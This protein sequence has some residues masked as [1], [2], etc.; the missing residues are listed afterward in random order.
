MIEYEVCSE[1]YLRS[2]KQVNPNRLSLDE[3]VFHIIGRPDQIWF[4]DSYCEI[5][6]YKTQA[7][8]NLI[9]KKGGTYVKSEDSKNI[10]CVIFGAQPSVRAIKYF[11]GKAKF[12]SAENAVRWLEKQVNYT[13]ACR[14]FGPKYHFSED[15]RLRP[16]QQLIKKRVFKIWES[17]YNIMIQLPTGTGKTVL[18]TSIINDLTKVKG[19]KI[20]ILAHRKELI[21][22]ISEHLSHYNIEH[23]L[24]TS[25][26]ARR[27]ELSVQ[28]AS[29]QTLT[30]EK[31]ID[32]LKEL[33]PQ[34]IIIDEAH[35]SLAE[36]YTKFWKECGNC[37]KLGV[38][39]TPY[40]LNLN[41]FLS[42][43]EKYVES[44][45]IEG[46]IRNGYLADYDFYTDNPNSYLSRTIESIK[47]KS[48]TRDYNTATLLRALNIQEHIQRLI[49]CYE[50]Y[51]KGKKGIVYAINKEHAHN[52]C[53]AYQIIGVKA[54]Y[55]DSD[56]PKSE[57][58]EIVE[59]FRDSE[60]Q[61]MVNV[62][63]FSEG[64]DCP[65]VEF[66]QLARP[67]W[68]LGKY[69]QQ[70]GRG[71][72]PS[73]NKQ[74]T[75]I[76]D[77]A[78]MFVKFGFPS[79]KR[80]WLTYFNGEFWL[81]DYQG[82]EEYDYV[83]YLCQA[84]T[85]RNEMMV[86]LNRGIGRTDKIVEVQAKQDKEDADLYR[87]IQVINYNAKLDKIKKEKEEARRKE[88]A[89]KKEARKKEQR[90]YV[91]EHT[92]RAILESPYFEKKA[93]VYGTFKNIGERDAEYVINALGAKVTQTI[94]PTTNFVFLADKSDFSWKDEVEVYDFHP[95][96]Y[97]EEEI[98][99][100]LELYKSI[101]P[102]IIDEDISK[103][104]PFYDLKV[105]GTGYLSWVLK[106]FGRI[107]ELFKFSRSVIC[108]ESEENADIYFLGINTD[109]DLYNRL[110]EKINDGKR[111][112]LLNY[113]VLD[114]LK[115][116]QTK[117]VA[118]IT[119]GK[120]A[121]TNDIVNTLSEYVLN[122]K[123]YTDQSIDQ[124]ETENGIRK[125]T[126]KESSPM[127]MESNIVENRTENPD[128]IITPE[129]ET[130]SNTQEIV[131]VPQKEESND[132]LQETIKKFGEIFPDAVKGGE[133]DFD[134]LKKV[135]DKNEA[136]LPVDL[137]RKESVIMPLNNIEHEVIE[138]TPHQTQR[139]ILAEPVPEYRK[140]QREVLQE[141]RHQRRLE[142]ERMQRS[143]EERMEREAQEAEQ[144][145][146]EEQRR[147]IFAAVGAVIITLV[148]IYFFGLLGPAVLGLL[149]GGL[150]AKK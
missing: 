146:R 1:T 101:Y 46:F 65:D 6:K 13:P 85:D 54:V 73:Q 22:Q 63:I 82:K 138:P 19:T 61:V 2:I 105:A 80:S 32:L 49:V 149:A 60:I 75:I 114:N 109:I 21:D 50:Q 26:K 108:D 56:T 51:V 69:L 117:I 58:Q 131:L 67:T 129:T 95:L 135:V 10:T 47:E 147:N 97:G 139:E 110:K 91:L 76:L 31:N 40:R 96:R 86:K 90:R 55:I 94:R 70:V 150:L 134:K 88:E 52:I 24:I 121:F 35:H 111:V 113:L 127:P 78:R 128:H 29:V 28:V 16:Y 38:T 136:V 53:N 99:S 14:A 3:E 142:R 83:K 143:Y 44:D 33:K 145:A 112:V 103:K 23:G 102:H 130:T 5:L 119:S 148:L 77:N 27:L 141:R 62:D 98:N 42:H 124:Y 126:S 106:D 144:A 123:Y 125:Q 45:N 84:N 39:A 37:W 140:S 116:T 30:H 120:P 59:Q 66:I 79:D 81:K 93:F 8:Y 11:E 15:S 9:E 87:T 17:H 41:G 36:S 133:V 68:S 57:R 74:R 107:S 7:L 92:P 71:M 4:N 18:F 20:V 43:F 137:Q 132:K 122:W 115:N 34:F 89:A 118:N 72:R 48:S 104:S 64:F 25:G 12:I 100:A